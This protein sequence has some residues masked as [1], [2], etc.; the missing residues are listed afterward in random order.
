MK[1]LVDAIKKL[2]VAM[3]CEWWEAIE[4]TIAYVELRES[5]IWMVRE[6]ALRLRWFWWLPWRREWGYRAGYWISEHWPRKWLP[7]L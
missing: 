6:E 2:Q 7:K 3:G 4:A 5:D 1:Q